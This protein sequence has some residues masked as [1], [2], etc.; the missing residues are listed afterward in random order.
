MPVITLPDKS[1]R[2]FDGPVTGT[3]V[4]AAIGP[5][6]ARAA[7]AMQLDGRLVDLETAID[8]DADVVFVTRRDPEA[9]GLI[10]HDAAHVLAEAVQEL[11]PGTQVT[12]GPAIAEGFYYDFARNEP[13]TPE[14]FAP[15]EARMREIVARGEK[16]VRQVIDRDEA[17]RFFQDK[18][19]K[20]KA[21]IIQDLP[22]DETITLY[23]QGNW[24][25]LCRGP[26]MRS[27]ADIG[28]AFKLMKVAGAYWRGD[29]RNA[30]LSR[31][32]GTAWRDQKELDAY[33]HM[34][35]EAERRDHRR[36]GKEMDL[37]H[38]QE[39]AM[40]SVFWHPKGWK[41]YLTA[42]AYLRRRLDD[43]GYQEV[44]TPQLVDRSL[45]ERSGH[46]E[47]FRQHMFIARVEDE[48]KTL[49]LKPMNCP[50]HIQIFRQGI[51]SYRELP[52]RLA[53]FG[54]CHRYE[55]SGALHGIMRVRAFTQD[56]AHIFCTE[57]QIAAET[58]RFVELLA[59]VYRDFGFPEFS[60]K[61]ADRPAIRIGQD[62][63][64]DQAEGALK[65]ACGIAGVEYT[66]N[67]GEGAFYGPK[68]EFVLRDAIGRDWQ[69][70]TLQVDFMLPELL[71]A[72]YVPEDG[73]RRRPVM[74]HRAIMGSF[75]RFLG[76][77]IEQYA[78][79]FPLWLAP[80]QA[81]VATIVSDADPYAGEVA[82]AMRAAGL[83]VGLDLSRQKIN[84]KVREHSLAHVPV[85]AVVGRR[86]AEQRTVALRRLGGDT[87]EVLA[88]DEAVR[89]L[90]VEATPPDLRER[91]PQAEFA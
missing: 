89:R 48:D 1:V 81:V 77:V 37:F 27:T 3:T 15:I 33:L 91:T 19:E 4:A 38:L 17:I 28:A 90:A 20:Y 16:F 58:V 66:L 41:L 8:H 11:Y 31:I 63:V 56:D 54:S 39:E 69:C 10:R 86:E 45:W 26:H 67:P 60:V 78:G 24:V 42:E 44:K 51:R 22:R 32:Y 70:G 25:D 46:W 75:E 29:H 34:L 36:I 12:I 65:E 49:A 59:S 62:A 23:R 6:L 83:A 88:L 14:D 68:L 82:S 74:L 43:A 52:L 73:V 21:E 84:A 53:E 7:L 64:W 72:E 80:V 5:G 55:P 13:F 9:L 61:F 30:M 18:G 47:K 57:Q 76:I 40:G 71:D 79:R 50:C 87:Q 35:E 85:L 2:R